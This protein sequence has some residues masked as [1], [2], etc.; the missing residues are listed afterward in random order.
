MIPVEEPPKQKLFIN[1]FLV[2][3][4]R[5]TRVGEKVADACF[6]SFMKAISCFWLFFGLLRELFQVL[7]WGTTAIRELIRQLVRASL[8]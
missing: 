5:Y 3:F 1:E 7:K 8:G 4:F 2:P 6:G